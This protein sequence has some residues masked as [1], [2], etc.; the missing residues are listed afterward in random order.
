MVADSQRPDIV[1]FS[2][3]IKQVVLL[4]LTVPLERMDEANQRKLARSPNLVEECRRR[5]WCASCVPIEVG[6][7]G[8]A[9]RSLC[10]ASSLLGIKGA[11]Q[12]KAFKT[13]TEA[14]KALRWLW[15]KRGKPMVHAT[16]RRSGTWDL[17]NRGWVA[18]V[19]VYDV[20]IPKTTYH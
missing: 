13:T 15:I 20:E 3:S 9:A 1:L 5:G 19:R 4:E 6:C 17:I 18:W 12:I 2:D 16:K 11:R 10:K 8:Y 7:G 14:D